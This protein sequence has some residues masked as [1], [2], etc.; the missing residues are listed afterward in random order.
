MLD[1]FEKVGF[2]WKYLNLSSTVS[3]CRWSERAL[4]KERM[5]GNLAPRPPRRN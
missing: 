5:T 2:R 4:Q 3:L 1:D